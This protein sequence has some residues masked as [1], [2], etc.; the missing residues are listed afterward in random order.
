MSLQTLNI[1]REWFP[2]RHECDWV[3]GTVIRTWGPVYRK[4]GAIMLFGSNNQQI[5]LL[6]GGCLEADIA[7]EARKVVQLGRAAVLHYD[8]SD[9]DNLAY[10]LGIGCG[11]SVDILLQAVNESNAYG[12]LLQALES[13]QQ[14][15][16]LVLLHEVPTGQGQIDCAIE[17]L[18]VDE[19]RQL[20]V[21]KQ[22]DGLLKT[23]EQTLY[24]NELVP[25]PSLLVV[26][27]G[28]DARPVVSM[29][30]LLGWHVLLADPRP[31]NARSEH[32]PAAAQIIRTDPAQWQASDG[33]LKIDAAI[34]MSH[35]LSLDAYALQALQ[36][37]S[38]R[39]IALLGPAERRQRV[40]DMV[41]LN[42]SALP[43]ALAGPAGL[44]LGGDLPE[45]I[46]LSILSECHASLHHTSAQS[47]SDVL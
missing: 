7:L 35:K 38:A 14:R 46:A 47:L 31:A 20:G 43:C 6:S 10:Q 1:L 29:A 23:A 22:G 15:Q 11:G 13:L 33:H 5:G 41:E 25:A 24:A 42:D 34:V 27:G 4:A 45:G 26:G 28:I 30:E 12:G 21:Q 19:F 39:Y 8:G 17:V 40:L 32:F 44:H 9:E 18:S 2:Q 3:L 37:S 16:A 36:H